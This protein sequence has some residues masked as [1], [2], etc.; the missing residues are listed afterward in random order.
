MKLDLR[1]EM[2]LS[3]VLR[4]SGMKGAEEPA[5]LHLASEAMEQVKKE[6]VPR[7]ICRQAARECLDPLLCGSDIN[8]H[9]QGCDSVCVIACTLGAEIDR[10]LSRL[11]VGN[12]ALAVVADAAASVAIESLAQTVEEQLRGAQKKQNRFLT[13]RFSPGYGDYP[14]EVQNQLLSFVDA[15]RKIGVFATETHLLVPRK[16]ITA[17]CGVSD[18]PVTGKLAGCENCALRDTCTKRKEGKTCA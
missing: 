7:A 8:A 16:S 5:L 13:G 10:F 6:A 3:E 14:I 17:L 15:P 1:F 9:L 4:L 18:H 11:Q 12:M 2:N